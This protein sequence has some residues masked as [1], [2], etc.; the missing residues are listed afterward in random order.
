MRRDILNSLAPSSHDCA[1]VPGPPPEIESLLAA[2]VA[3]RPSGVVGVAAIESSEIAWT[4]FAGGDGDTLFQ[5]GS[6]SKTV[7]S[8]V[9]LRLVERGEL[10]LDSGVAGGTT[11]RA[12]LGHTSGADAPFYP[13]YPQD[14]EV[15]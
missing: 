2:A 12:L 3:R 5:A 1:F 15:P 14:S 11:L 8:T 4:A 9:A 10:D 13:G 6:L 7:T